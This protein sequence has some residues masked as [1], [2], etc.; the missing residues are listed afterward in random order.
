MSP[1]LGYSEVNLH[2][3]LMMI[4]IDGVAWCTDSRSAAFSAVGS[5]CTDRKRCDRASESGWCVCVCLLF[6]SS[7]HSG[8][9]RYIGSSLNYRLLFLFPRHRAISEALLCSGVWF[10]RC[11]FSRQMCCQGSFSSRF[12]VSKS[13]E[14]HVAIPVQNICKM[15]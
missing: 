11:F 10:S 7:F 8:L 9:N 14:K 4:R 2:L 12:T 15:L 5:V 13:R 6:F 3:W 1:R